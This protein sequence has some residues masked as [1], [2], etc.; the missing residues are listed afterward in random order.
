MTRK[1]SEPISLDIR[2]AI[3]S[4][5]YHSLRSWRVAGR[6]GP[7]SPDDRPGDAGQMMV[8]SQGRRCCEDL[9]G[10]VAELLAGFGAPREQRVEARVRALDGELALC[11]RPARQIT[12]RFI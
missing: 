9:I 12:G 5:D 4:D 6:V 10:L 7:G 1:K 3:N 2:R 11:T 8:R